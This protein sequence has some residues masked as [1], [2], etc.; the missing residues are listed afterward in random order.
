MLI[1]AVYIESRRSFFLQKAVKYS[2]PSTRTVSTGSTTTNPHP[3]T[4]A[5][6]RTAV[7]RFRI[8]RFLH[9]AIASREAEINREE[10]RRPCDAVAAHRRRLSGSD[11]ARQR[12]DVAWLDGRALAIGVAELC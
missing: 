9:S 11:G 8:S 5:P 7:S 1:V 2:P 3:A 12:D 6:I 4:S 10:R